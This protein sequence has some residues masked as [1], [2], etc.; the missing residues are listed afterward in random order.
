M[1]MPGRTVER[2]HGGS[3]GEAA[4]PLKT[5]LLKQRELTDFE[6]YLKDETGQISGSFKYRGVYHRIKGI[7]RDITLVAASTGNHGLAVATVCAQRGAR[8]EIFVPRTISPCKHNILAKTG[9]TIHRDATTYHD[10]LQMALRRGDE[11][12]CLFVPS[13]DSEEAVE[14]HFELVEETLSQVGQD[15]A[16]VFVPCGGG[17]LLAAFCSRARPN[18]TVVGVQLDTAASMALSLERGRRIAVT[19]GPTAADGLAVPLCGEV[20]FQRC[21]QYRPEILRVTEREILAAM[22][23]LRQCSGINAEGAGAAS[24]AGALKCRPKGK[25]V[26]MITGGNVSFTLSNEP[27][28]SR[29]T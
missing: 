1:R 10:T 4:T 3:S 23:T 7:S 13:F 26:C 20:P 12:G 14:A 6:I 27:V 11:S 21:I 5:P 24:L 8:C 29:P 9:A 15:P 25:A 18:I 2:E 22:E 28:V 17:G 19:V 16:S